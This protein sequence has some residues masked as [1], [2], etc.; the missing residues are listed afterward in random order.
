MTVTINRPVPT[1]RAAT[2]APS[3]RGGATLRSALRAVHLA[4]AGAVGTLVYAPEHVAAP[5]RPW[6]QVVGIPLLTA[7]GVAMWQQARV[8]RAWRAAVARWGRT[9]LAVA[10]VLLVGF[11]HHVDHVLRYENSGWPFRPDVTPF[12]V[13]LVAYPLLAAVLLLRGR[14]LTRG[15]LLLAGYAATQISHVVFETPLV[16]YDSWAEGHGPHGHENLLHVTSPAL[17]VA[18]TTLSLLLS[19][20]FLAAVAST[21]ADARAARRATA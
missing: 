20:A 3:R 4:G 11:A 13:S 2:A 6:M 12:T 9:E 18:S 21:L 16:Q 7:T 1:S 15:V 5:L 10:A 8:R 17:G 14:P 19:A